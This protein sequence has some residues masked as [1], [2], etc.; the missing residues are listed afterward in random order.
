MPFLCIHTTPDSSA[1]VNFSS[2]YGFQEDAKK[3]F[4]FKMSRLI[5]LEL[6]VES[7]E[8][9]LFSAIG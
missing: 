8:F 7:A 6:V 1:K 3:K 9:P 2:Y 5:V 4:P